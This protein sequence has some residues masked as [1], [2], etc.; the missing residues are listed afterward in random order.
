MA[1]RQQIN[2]PHRLNDVPYDARLRFADAY[3]NKCAR[4]LCDKCVIWCG[5]TDHKGYGQFKMEGRAHWAHR[6]SYA[7]FVG[8]IPEG[9]TV[10]HV[11]QCR[12]P[13]CVNPK[14]LEL[15]TI[16]DNTAVGNRNRKT[17]TF[18]DNVPF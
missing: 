13:S 17:R 8:P 11:N 16:A 18:N 3:F 1:K 10:N 4:T 14:H 7:M 9:M 5:H 2:S 12:N 6:V 15:L